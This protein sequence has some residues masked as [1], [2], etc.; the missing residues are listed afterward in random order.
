MSKARLVVIILSVLAG[1]VIMAV[2]IVPLNLALLR[3][4]TGG[5]MCASTKWLDS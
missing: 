5:G 1:T 4:L 2:L 3:A